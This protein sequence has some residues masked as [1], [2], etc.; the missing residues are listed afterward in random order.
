MATHTFKLVQ[1][2]TTLFDFQSKSVNVLSSWSPQ[3]YKHENKT[4]EDTLIVNPVGTSTAALYDNLISLW[5]ALEIAAFNYMLWQNGTSYTP[6]Y[7]QFQDSRLSHMM[8]TEVFGGDRDKFDNMLSAALRANVVPNI[9]LTIIRRPYWE[10]AGS[11]NTQA[12]LTAQVISGDGGYLDISGIRG[13]VPAATTIAL[14]AGIANQDQVV[15]AFKAKG[16]PS[17]FV[18]IYEAES[19]TYRNVSSYSSPSNG[20]DVSASTVDANMSNGARVRFT[21]S[22]TTEV[23]LLIW[24]IT[25]NVSDQMGTYRVFVRCRDNH[26]SVNVK[27]RVRGGVY[28][29]SV[30]Y[31]WG[32]YGAPAKYV[33][34]R[35][36]DGNTSSVAGTTAIPLVDCGVI[37]LPPF[38]TGGVVPTTLAIELLGEA[39]SA[40]GKTFDID[41]IYLM[42]CY[43]L[44]MGRGLIT[45][46]FPGSL[47][48]SYTPYGIITSIDRSVP[49]YTGSPTLLQ[50][51]SDIR[52]G[53]PYLWTNQSI[54][55]FILTLYSSQNRHTQNS[56]HTVTMTATPRYRFGRGS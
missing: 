37:D 56:N 27:I 18:N 13:D 47:G 6:V 41:C 50:P 52:G 3:V 22:G 49:A 16:T 45:Y 46:N 2:A 53:S 30:G 33:D 43:E 19:F 9:P 12:L 24:N 55:M 1:G 35:G 25:S 14:T 38:D 5:R 51:A 15:L 26:T 48:T 20:S 44:P 23:S 31:R 8:Q 32:D 10:Q 40:G 11:N 29:T 34:G 42:P 36:V 28:D 7:L 39:D 54:R 4:I 17:N 21:P